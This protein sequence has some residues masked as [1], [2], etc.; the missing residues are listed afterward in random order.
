MTGV[1]KPFVNQKWNA[2]VL[3]WCER[4]C[5]NTTLS[6]VKKQDKKFKK[7]LWECHRYKIKVRRSQ[8]REFCGSFKTQKTK[9][10]CFCTRKWPILPCKMI[11]FGE[12]NGPFCDV[13]RLILKTGMIFSLKMFGLFTVLEAILVLKSQ[14]NRT[15]F[16]S[17]FSW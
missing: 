11:H 4:I 7:V 13:K 10:L 16:W 5:P 12:Q 8:I 1:K 9:Y 14:K 3:K 17:I 15:G 2:V 6:T